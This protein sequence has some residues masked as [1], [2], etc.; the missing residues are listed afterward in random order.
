MS[1]NAEE[2]P[3]PCAACGARAGHSQLYPTSRVETGS[4]GV[5]CNTPPYETTVEVSRGTIA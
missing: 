1:G 3:E 5:P 4:A 2:S